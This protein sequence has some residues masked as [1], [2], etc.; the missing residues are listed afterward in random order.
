MEKLTPAEEAAMLTLWRLER[1][2]LGVLVEAMPEPRPHYNTLASTCKNLE[3]KGYVSFRRYGNVYEYFPKVSREEM[4][5]RVV[6]EYF[7]DSYKNLVTH[8][9]KEHKISAEELREILS[10]IEKGK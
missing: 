5:G 7:Q 10:M 8:F 2:T 9:A 3:R 6:E 4:A 1:A